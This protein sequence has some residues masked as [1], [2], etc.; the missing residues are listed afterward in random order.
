M[1]KGGSAEDEA[2]AAAEYAASAIEKAKSE[3]PGILDKLGKESE[4]VTEKIKGTGKKVLDS[5]KE[6]PK[7]SAAV[8]T[9]LA[10]GLGALALRK[11]LKTLKK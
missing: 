2:K 8:A 9:A 3:N 7:M 4:N 11:R 5:V 1:L 6:N 10:A